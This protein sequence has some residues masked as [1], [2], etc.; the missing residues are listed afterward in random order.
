MSKDPEEL[1]R[2]FWE[3]FE[4]RG[5]VIWKDMR[6]FILKNFNFLSKEQQKLISKWCFQIL[7]LGCNSGKY[8]LNLIKK[9]FCD[10]H[11]SSWRCK[12][13][14]QT[15]QG[16]VY[17]HPNVQVPG[18]LKLCKL[19]CKL[20]SMGENVWGQAFEIMAAAW[21]AWLCRQAGLSSLA[22]FQNW[23]TSLYCPLKST[24]TVSECSGS[25]R[26]KGI[27]IGWSI[28]KTLMLNPF[29]NPCRPCKSFTRGWEFK[30]QCC[31]RESQWN[32]SCGAHWNKEMPWSCTPQGRRP[33]KCWNK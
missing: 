18:H 17:V 5:A 27:P 2:K 3:A 19:G 12:S 32:I 14:K 33:T 30:E 10:P 25:W 9:C 13:G 16:H 6:H 31:W 15:K 29:W 28:T 23:K 4:C 21:V 26:W 11:R 24:R 7:V 8:D 1:V 20:W 22:T